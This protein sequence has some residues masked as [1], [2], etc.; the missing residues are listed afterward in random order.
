MDTL[1]LYFAVLVLFGFSLLKD[2]NKTILALKKGL[3]ALEGI[4]PQFITVLLF[5]A[6][7]LSIFDSQFITKLLGAK[8]GWVGVIV[9]SALGSVTLIPGFVAFPLA[10]ELMRNGAGGLQ[11]TTFV[12]SLM[13]VGIVTLPMEI[14]VF[15]RRAAILRNVFALVFSF[16]AA[17]FVAW[18]VQL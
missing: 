17:F 15:G 16:I 12:S 14:S 7:I 6:V 11:I 13:M 10:G 9:A 4:M 18:V 3:K 1:I 2:R 8:T 5:I